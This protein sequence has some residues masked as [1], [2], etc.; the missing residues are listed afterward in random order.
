MA[1]QWRSLHTHQSY[2]RRTINILDGDCSYTHT[3]PGKDK[4]T[5]LQIPLIGQQGPSQDAPLQWETLEKPKIKGGRGIRNI[6]KFNKALATNSLWLVLNTNGIWSSFIKDTYFPYTSV[7]SWLCTGTSHTRFASQIWRNLVKSTLWITN[8]LC[9]KPSSGHSMIIRKDCIIGINQASYL[10][11][12]LISI[13]NTKNTCFL[14][15]AR[16]FNE[17]GTLTV[18]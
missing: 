18:D 2:P 15:Q 16:H 3:G 11:T 12:Q 9:W 14:F 1:L 5:H 7:A 10:S 8:W 6:F 4:K 17:L 13:L